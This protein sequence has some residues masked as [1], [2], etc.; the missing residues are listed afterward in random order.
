ML[1]APPLPGPPAT[2]IFAA[3]RPAGRVFPRFRGSDPELT[4]AAW[5]R[6]G[7]PA[8][9][10]GTVPYATFIF[11][12]TLGGAV[13]SP[14]ADCTF[15]CRLDAGA[16]ESCVSPLH[17]S[18]LAPGEHL[19]Q[20]RASR[21]D[22]TPDALAAYHAWALE[23]GPWVGF[24]TVL[25]AAV[26][27]S[28]VDFTIVGADGCAL[29]YSMDGTT[30]APASAANYSAPV[31]LAVAI[32]SEG[33]NTLR[34]ACA[35]GN[36]VPATAKHTWR[37][38]TWP[39]AAS[40]SQGGL[41]AGAVLHR[42]SASWL[43]SANDADAD[44]RAGSGVGAF[45]CRLVAHPANT[46]APPPLS[47]WSACSTDGSVTLDGL[48]ALVSGSYALQLRAVDHAGNTGAAV[49]SLFDV[50]DTLPLTPSATVV[51]A[52]ITLAPSPLSMQTTLFYYITNMSN[53]AL[54]LADGVTAVADNSF[55]G[56]ADGAGLLFVPTASLFS[57]DARDSQFGFD[58]QAADAA[59]DAR[60]G[61]EAVHASVTVAHVN[62]APVVDASHFFAL[63]DLY[64]TGVSLH[65]AALGEA[66]ADVLGSG[67]S[68][69]DGDAVGLA[70]T[71]A[72]SALGAWESSNNSGV[73]WLPLAGASAT[74][75][76]LLGGGAADRLR[77]TPRLDA[78]GGLS[79]M[80]WAAT[81][82]LAFLAWDGTDDNV[83]GTSCRTVAADSAAAA[84]AAALDATFAELVE[85]AL[86]AGGG[87]VCAP[88]NTTYVRTGAFSAATGVAVV[89]I[90]DAAH[91]RGTAALSSAARLAAS[92]FAAA[93]AGCPPQR[94][95]A[96]ELPPS[97]RGAALMLSGGTLPDL[98]PP[99][100]VEAWIRKRARLAS[101]VLLASAAYPAVNS[102]ALLLEAAPATFMLG[103]RR[104]GGW[105]DGSASDVSLGVEAPLGVWTHIAFVDDGIGPLRL[106]V[107][108]VLAGAAALGGLPLPRGWV[109]HP[110][111]ASAFAIDELRIWTVARSAQQLTAA[112][113]ALLPP[114][115]AVLG[116]GDGASADG[117][118]A[119]LRFEEG[120][121]ASASD[122]AAANMT[123]ALVGAAAWTRGVD[124][125]C[126]T[127]VGI[128]PA[129]GPPAGGGLL[130]LLGAGFPTPRSAAAA[131]VFSNGQRALAVRATAGTVTCVAPPA[132]GRA[133][134]RVWYEDT[135]RGCVS[136]QA[137]V[138]TYTAAA[139]AAVHPPVGPAGGGAL[140]T[141]SGFG[142][143]AP[144]GDAL[145][146][147]TPLPAGA[148]GAPAQLATARIM[149][150][151][152]LVCEAPALATARA[153]LVEVSVNGGDDWL[154]DAQRVTFLVADA[155]SASPLL[156]QTGP[157][158]GGA[159]LRVL[160]PPHDTGALPMTALP[161]CGFGTLRPVAARLAGAHAMECVS[162]ARVRGPTPLLTSLNGRDWEQRTRFVAHS[163][164]RVELLYPED[165]PAGGGAVLTVLGSGGAA[166]RLLSCLFGGS[167]A[168]GT[169]P[170]DAHTARGLGLRVG[171]GVRCVAPSTAPGFVALR[172]AGDG[173]AGP[174]GRD[175]VLQ[176]LAREAPHT[177]AAFPR[178]LAAGGGTLVAVTGSSFMPIALCAFGAGAAE[179][180]LHFVSTALALCE[181]PAA[182]ACPSTVAVA[183]PL[184][185]A[186]TATA[187]EYEGVPAAA[188]STRD[189]AAGETEL[190]AD[191]IGALH[192]AI[193][194]FGTTGVVAA[195]AGCDGLARPA[196]SGAVPIGTGSCWQDVTFS[197]NATLAYSQPLELSV[198]AAVSPP[199]GA[200]TGSFVL[201][202]YID[203]LLLAA[204]P[205]MA[206]HFFESA[207]A[208]AAA[209]SVVGGAARCTAPPTS[210]AGGGFVVVRVSTVAQSPADIAAAQFMYEP[211]A[212][213]TSVLVPRAGALGTDAAGRLQ[214]GRLLWG[215][216]PVAVA[217]TH[218]PG[219]AGAA[220]RFGSMVRPAHWV[221]TALAHCEPPDAAV[222]GA[223]LPDAYLSIAHA[224]ASADRAAWSPV[225][226][227]SVFSWPRASDEDSN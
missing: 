5:V 57:G 164:P 86:D 41:P 59:S 114:P 216:R 188:N 150:S 219:S 184:S 134:V 225:S 107:N 125:A 144:A 165:A 162:P 175:G 26:N 44:A 178:V 172:I 194:A 18:G 211:R 60:L 64:N 20:V 87:D 7:V 208:S 187:I 13:L 133:S 203:A 156:L 173:V 126:A 223:A 103:V 79:T 149:S 54:F 220:C 139:V 158:S 177:I 209:A 24:A 17:L 94:P 160:L 75:P 221:S 16:W 92:A 205:P 28:L 78:L 110:L 96:V 121:G 56:A 14:C 115:V 201:T 157:T 196:A 105:P 108:G 146:R 135:V 95:S 47:D 63:L 163:P 212:R 22:G 217:G 174:P 77:F 140:I 27:T 154:P 147:F 21:A 91:L 12:A 23:L 215:G 66:V 72:D 170:A 181:A 131:C 38:D 61:G 101:T 98:T 155:P 124:L 202:L 51:Q 145:C 127:V 167:S 117:L 120:C 207:H 43:V 68:D 97:P 62:S 65:D 111:S 182:T 37:L 168:D 113:Q 166:A 45:E 67:A 109:G 80:D 214:P 179:T 50:D 42:D 93:V 159:V 197:A 218:L 52:S 186:P 73:S 53:G 85:L 34:V 171:Q 31:V 200:V 129:A 19:F 88:L 136:T 104:V 32:S 74:S 25:A 161:V 210:F 10:I 192:A 123:A 39:P 153:C 4:L 141:L 81:A 2:A 206:C 8:E 69:A 128:Q 40:F 119:V 176:Y 204:E 90:Y 84:A 122:S 76:R 199:F 198:D 33:F 189:A 143:H 213:V 89:A 148:D 137:V 55:I 83:A 29:S 180:P 11:A 191:G 169:A 222:D 3:S 102:T 6:P 183:L 82:S 227:A 46:T 35:L 1:A 36:A 226:S 193:C 185:H 116:D 195:A 15:V 99:W 112:W 132:A 70:I 138:Y 142:F 58:V 152:L 151:S 49:E 106:F 224:L 130:T 9:A 118:N 48:L 100:T 71:S 190:A 30:W